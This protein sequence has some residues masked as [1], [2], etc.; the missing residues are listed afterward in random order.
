MSIGRHCLLIATNQVEPTIQPIAAMGESVESGAPWVPDDSTT[1]KKLRGYGLP[2]SRTLRTMRLSGKLVNGEHFY[3]VGN[4][5]RVVYS[6]PRIRQLLIE[7]SK[8]RTPETYE[9]EVG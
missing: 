2:S 4:N 9:Q 5:G 6:V 7:L 1:R 3:V 8:R